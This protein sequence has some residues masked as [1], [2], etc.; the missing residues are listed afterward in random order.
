MEKAKRRLREPGGR[1]G[2]DLI[3]LIA[4]P[5]V[6]LCGGIVG[7]RTKEDNTSYLVRSVVHVLLGHSMRNLGKGETSPTQGR[8]GQKGLAVTI[9]KAGSPVQPSAGLQLFQ[10]KPYAGDPVVQ[11]SGH[12]Q[13]WK[14][15]IRKKKMAMRAPPYLFR[16]DGM[17]RHMQAVRDTRTITLLPTLSGNSRV[18]QLFQGT[19]LSGM[20]VQSQLE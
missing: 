4:H 1:A 15:R 3:Q 5:L 2:R 14:K 6:R 12:L 20:A 7:H 8:R 9:P 11:V 10:L 18:F 16:F 13:G 17:R 19:D